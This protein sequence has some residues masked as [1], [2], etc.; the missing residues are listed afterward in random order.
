MLAPRHT[1]GLAETQIRPID[2]AWRLLFATVGSGRS[3]RSPQVTKMGRR[4]AAEP[5]CAVDGIGSSLRA[6]TRDAWLGF[7]QGELHRGRSFVHAKPTFSI[8]APKTVGLERFDFLR[9]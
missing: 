7:G 3:P 8:A 5:N 4:F 2:A 6:R 9:Y 1:S